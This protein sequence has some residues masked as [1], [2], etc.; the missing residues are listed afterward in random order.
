MNEADILKNICEDVYEEIT[1]YLETR[2]LDI[3]LYCYENFENE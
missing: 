3:D 2:D 1:E